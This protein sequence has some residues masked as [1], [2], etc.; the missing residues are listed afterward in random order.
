MK[1][2]TVVMP[3]NL[4]EQELETIYHLGGFLWRKYNKNR[5]Y[6][7]ELE[8]RFLGLKEE[9]TQEY[10]EIIKAMKTGYIDIDFRNYFLVSEGTEEATKKLAKIIEDGVKK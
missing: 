8:I 6:L 9:D 10:K 4:T 5:I 2:N 7:D 3:I 1:K